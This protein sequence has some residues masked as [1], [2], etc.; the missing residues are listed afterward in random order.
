VT[1]SNH[2][3]RIDRYRREQVEAF[4]HELGVEL[5]DVRSR[6][7]GPRWRVNAAFYCGLEKATGTRIFHVT[8]PD[9]KMRNTLLEC[10]ASSH[11]LSYAQMKEQRKGALEDYVRTDE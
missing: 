9:R 10:G 11:L 4:L 3:D 5:G 8:N 1:R 7:P 6:S 2:I